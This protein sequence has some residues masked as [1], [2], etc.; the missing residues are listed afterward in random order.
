MTTEV[1]VLTAFEDK[2]KERIRSGIGE[3]MP[4][5]AL[6]KI[7]ERGIEEAFFKVIEERDS[8]GRTTKVAP[9]IVKFLQVKCQQ[10]VEKQV[11]EWISHNSEKLSDLAK[12][13]I[14]NGLATATLNTFARLWQ[15]PLNQLQ[16]TISKKFES[17]GVNT[18]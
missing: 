11:T 12:Q 1:S 7:V 4:D 6:A 16:T 17:M 3:L 15:E 18:F 14:E 5:E 8:W 9:W 10:R 13:S 2:M